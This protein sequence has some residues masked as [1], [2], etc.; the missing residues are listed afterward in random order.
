MLS[1]VKLLATARVVPVPP[2]LAA[3]MVA[4]SSVCDPNATKVN[5]L[6]HVVPTGAARIGPPSGPPA[7]LKQMAVS[8]VAFPSSWNTPLESSTPPP[9]LE[10]WANET[11]VIPSSRHNRTAPEGPGNRSHKQSSIRIPKL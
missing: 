6:G 5:P 1:L 9:G 11:P 4:Q 3:K 7:R 10:D 8:F 2:L